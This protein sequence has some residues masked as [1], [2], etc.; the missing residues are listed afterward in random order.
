M[1]CSVE[2]VPASLARQSR[3][4]GGAWPLQHCTVRPTVAPETLRGRQAVLRRH[5][6]I[7][8]PARA[9]AASADQPDMLQPSHRQAVFIQI[10]EATKWAVTAAV[11]AVLLW[12]HDVHS[13]W[14]VVGCVASSFVCKVLKQLIN[15]QR[16]TGARKTDGGMPSSHANNLGFLATYVDVTCWHASQGLTD[17]TMPLLT[18]AGVTAVA[19]FLAYLRIA[20]GYHSPAQVIVGFGLGSLSSIIWHRLGLATVLNP[21]QGH[22]IIYLQLVTGAAAIIWALVNVRQWMKESLPRQDAAH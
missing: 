11:A 8:A 15:Q 7:E 13:M 4:S 12:R 14:S 2:L 10:N 16:P 5:L 3:R 18:S 6:A 22:L 1:L 9:L 17:S 21:S 19:L 20:T